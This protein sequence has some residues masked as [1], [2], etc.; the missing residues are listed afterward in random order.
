M[1]SL[2]LLIFTIAC[3]PGIPKT[4]ETAI[5][6]A[7]QD[8]DGDGYV[9]L[10][11][12]DDDDFDVNPAAAERCDGL[13]NDCDGEIDE[14]GTASEPLFA[15][16]DGDGFGDPDAPVE[17]CDADD[18][19]VINGADC[20]DGDDTVYPDA[21]ERCDGLDNDCDGD[22]DEDAS[23]RW[24][25]EDGDGYGDAD[26]VT[27][28]CEDLDGW[29]DDDTDCDDDD[30]DVHPGADE[31]CGDGLDA[32]C[33]GLPCRLEDDL[34]VPGDALALITGSESSEYVGKSVAIADINGDDQADV[35]VT[36]PAYDASGELLDC[37]GAWV[38]YGPVSGTQ[39]IE[40]YDGVAY[41]PEWSYAGYSLTS[42]G[43]ADADGYD[44]LAI[45][46][47]DSLVLLVAGPLDDADGSYDSAIEIE[48]T[49]SDNLA[50]LALVTDGGKGEAALL[51]GLPTWRIAGYGEYGRVAVFDDPLDAESTADARM[52][53]T[54]AEASQYTGR[55]LAG[56]ADLDG[57]GVH[58]VLVGAPGYAPDATLSKAGA[59]AIVPAD[60]SDEVS[61]ADYV[62]LEGDESKCLLGWD[63]AD[64]GDW[65]GDGRH[66]L[67]IGGPGCGSSGGTTGAAWIMT[68]LGSGG[69]WSSVVATF[70]GSARSDALGAAVLGVGDADDD[71]FADVAI[72]APSPVD[73]SVWT[74][75]EVGVWFGGVEGAWGLKE[76]DLYMS[77]DEGSQF[78]Y[79]LAGGQDLTGDGLPDLAVSGPQIESEAGVVAILPLVGW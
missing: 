27:E 64:A 7:W 1:R 69:G 77:S 9:G 66:D 49:L 28:A 43:D 60:G 71:G 73:A 47:K 14:A 46:T 39:T 41:G 29:V 57:D 48:G 74:D 20:D 40:K 67:I 34:D 11:D 72:G 50:P 62:V 6:A 12:C 38:F 13:D 23:P 2:F 5:D 76:A 63:V 51:M 55:G 25:D 19:A 70:E 53:I 4:G 59:V 37:G 8:A 45:G 52:V 78:G 31:V 24:A 30:A 33:D 58:E 61:F 18:G 16:A 79:R 22:T 35:V 17:S 15:D 42:L 3:Q 44:D 10:D 21:E 56:G 54:S 68:D 26:R 36:A 65:D 32:D 75:G